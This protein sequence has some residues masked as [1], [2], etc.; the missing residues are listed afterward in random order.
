[1]NIKENNINYTRIYTVIF[2]LFGGII[3]SCQSNHV[4]KVK[5]ANIVLQKDVVETELICPDS[6]IQIVSDEQNHNHEKDSIVITKISTDFFYWYIS[7]AK[8][9]NFSEYNPI[10][11][12]DTNGM[13]TLNFSK[14]FQ[15]LVNLSFSDSLLTKEKRSYKKCMLNLAKVNYSDYLKL[16][17][18]EDFESLNCDFGNYYRWTGGQEMFDGYSVTKMELEKENAIVKGLLFF[19]DTEKIEIRN[20]EREISMI[21]IKQKDKWKILDIIY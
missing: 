16:E 20:F 13:T 8:E 1:M 5:S 18:L 12:Q 9:N 17:D 14:Y 6:T 15:N 2:S 7:N 10:E 19:N 11:I 4:E 3:L 21:F